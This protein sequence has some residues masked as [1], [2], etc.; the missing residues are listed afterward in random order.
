MHEER[1]MHVIFISE[2]IKAQDNTIS[3]VFRSN[4]Y[5]ISYSKS[6]IDS[7]LYHWELGYSISKRSNFLLSCH[8]NSYY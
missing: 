6:T 2:E 4:F 7:N 8:M 5:L 1:N 3:K